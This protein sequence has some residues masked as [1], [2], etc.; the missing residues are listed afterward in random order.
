MFN[1]KQVDFVCGENLHA[2]DA[3]DPNGEIMVFGS[4]GELILRKD[5]HVGLITKR[6]IYVEGKVTSL[7]AVNGD[8]ELEIDNDM[9]YPVKNLQMVMI[10]I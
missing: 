10:G 7:L 1:N 9:K 3:G 5:E 6:D 2:T 4:N 8:I